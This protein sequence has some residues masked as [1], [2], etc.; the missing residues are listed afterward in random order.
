MRLHRPIAPL[1]IL[2]VCAA[3]FSAEAAAKPPVLFGVHGVIE[4]IAADGPRVALET[5]ATGGC[6]RVVTWNEATSAFS[7]WKTGINCAGG[8][9]SAGQSVTELALAGTTA[10]W[11]EETAGNL[12]DLSVSTAA[13]GQA[14]VKSNVDFAENGN[15]AASDP[16]G[17]YLG[18]LFGNGPV[19]AYN[20]WHVCEALAPG[21]VDESAMAICSAA[22]S[23]GK[24]VDQVENASLRTDIGETVKT[25]ASGPRM[26]MVVAVNAGRIAVQQS[27]GSVLLYSSAGAYQ[28]SIP[29][30]AG[31]FAGTEL[32]GNQLV[33]L[34]NGS[35]EVYDT[36]TGALSKSIPITAPKPTLRGF[37]GG[38]AVYLS[39]ATVRVI[40]L[41][42]GK[43][44]TIR[45]PG[46]AP[47]DVQIDPS[48]L[49]Y[50]Y[51]VPTNKTAPGRVAF[52][53]TAAVASLF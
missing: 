9:T 36:G 20:T 30:P 34:R 28:R 13:I 22:S 47:A 42:D 1:L 26:F 32:S 8:A 21:A 48:G 52:L 5:T 6:D 4:R 14:T 16:T 17:D 44:V 43:D 50:S 25:A 37:S 2:A 31:V 41:S 39:G 23:T 51:N 7:V 19:I 35:L 12:E 29:V 10:A 15:G 33:T 53:S 11:V 18:Q 45:V 27:N 38:F 24:T 3:V 49:F 46:S 40:R